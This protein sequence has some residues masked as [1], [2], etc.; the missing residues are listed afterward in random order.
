M[1]DQIPK[2]NISVTIIAISTIY[3][4]YKSQ[5]STVK[6]TRYTMEQRAKMVELYFRCNCSV[7][8]VRRNY[9]NIYAIG[10]P[11]KTC[12]KTLCTKF[13]ETETT[14]AHRQGCGKTRAIQDDASIQLVEASAA[15]QHKS[16]TRRRLIQL[17]FSCT[18]LQRILVKDLKHHPYKILLTRKLHPTNYQKPSDFAGRFLQLAENE[19]F[20]KNLIVTNEAHFHLNGFANKQ[21]CRFWASENPKEI[22]E[23]PLHSAIVTV[24]RGITSSRIIGPYVFSRC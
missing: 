16:S 2:F 19:N 14:A 5:K 8:A 1:K 21:N 6:M 20:V 13:Q 7:A 9:R 15:D 23:R 3:R 12:I 24:W 18:S 22:Y 11:S 4:S 10:S 17:G